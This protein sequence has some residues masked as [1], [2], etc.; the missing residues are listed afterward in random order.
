MVAGEKSSAKAETRLGKGGKELRAGR[1][2]KQV[3][4]DAEDIVK[5][6]PGRNDVPVSA[7]CKVVWY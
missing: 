4:G 7:S 6:K 1:T 2:N 3:K 5:K